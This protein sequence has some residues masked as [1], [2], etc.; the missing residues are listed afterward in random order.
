[1]LA[2]IGFFAVVAGQC[3]EE[4]VIIWLLEITIKVYHPVAIFLRR[5]ATDYILIFQ[6]VAL[7]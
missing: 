3:C 4:R 7:I 2:D 5:Q 1:M 6:C